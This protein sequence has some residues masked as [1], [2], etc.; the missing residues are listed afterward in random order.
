MAGGAALAACTEVSM[1]PAA[2]TVGFPATWPTDGRVGGVPDPATA[3]PDIVQIGSEGGLLPAPAIWKAQPVTY[4]QNVRNITVF[5]I[6]NH[7]L[8][9]GGGE[10]ADVLVDFSKYA[11]K[12]LI[13]YN[14]APA[15]MPGYDPRIDYYTGMGDYT[16]C[17]RCLRH[18]ARLWSEHAYR[19]AVQGEQHRTCSV[20]WT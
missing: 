15:P 9:M 2:P 11:G 16:K 5:N 19:D 7:G 10:R 20:L 12:T 8:L 1:V 4:D 17:R 6:L 14:D 18:P 13:L 3:G